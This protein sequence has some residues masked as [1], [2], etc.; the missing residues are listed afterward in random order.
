E[1]RPVRACPAVFS[2]HSR[3]RCISIRLFRTRGKLFM[4]YCAFLHSAAALFVSTERAA[5]SRY[6]PNHKPLMT[7]DSNSKS[8]AAAAACTATLLA[9]TIL[10]P[11]AQAAD[12]QPANKGW[13]TVA[14]A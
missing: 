13:E 2:F 5:G 8:V 4:L 3:M 9:G 12:P 14:S 10:S 7:K 6:K 11:Q 1:M